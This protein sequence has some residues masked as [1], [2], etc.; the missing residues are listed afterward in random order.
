MH[1]I[2]SDHS[3]NGIGIKDLGVLPKEHLS[4]ALLSTHP[5]KNHPECPL[6]SAR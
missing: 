3:Q 1:S 4:S 6:V 2:M 5:K